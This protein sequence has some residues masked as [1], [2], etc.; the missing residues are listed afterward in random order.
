M[1]IAWATDIH[2]DHTKKIT[3]IAFYDSIKNMNPDILLISGDI[4]NS[5]SLKSFLYEI[6]N[7]QTESL[8]SLF[9]VLGNHD[10]Y[11]SSI[12]TVRKVASK[13]IGYLTNRSFIDLGTIAL[14]GHDGWYDARNGRIGK[15]VLNDFTL[16]DEFRNCINVNLM[17]DKFD[18]LAKE[19]ANHFKK[20]LELAFKTYDKVI[21]LT[22]VA[23]FAES[24]WYNG[25]MSDINWLPYFSSRVEGDTLLEVMKAYPN[26]ELLVLCGHSHGKG[27]YKP[28]DN[29]RVL[30]GDAEYQHP[31]LQDAFVF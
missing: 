4:A 16:I 23:P 20:N 13:F 30:T 28:L 26:K 6:N 8:M 17:Y 5:K 9:F 19:A 31:K 11:G 29:L 25:Q 27:E 7:I 12:K 14:I 21:L 15:I 1:K 2:L 3:R 24:A 10:F 22:H 18:S